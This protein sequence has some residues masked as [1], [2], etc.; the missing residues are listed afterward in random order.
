MLGNTYD[1]DHKRRRFLMLDMVHN[2]C[3]E[4]QQQ[5]LYASHI[6]DIF[7]LKPQ[8]LSLPDRIL[9][10][11]MGKQCAGEFLRDLEEVYDEYRF[12]QFSNANFD[13]DGINLLLA[14]ANLTQLTHEDAHLS[15]FK[16]RL[17]K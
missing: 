2:I 3:F 1:E 12:K 13:W 5:S 4:S 6:K 15:R 16:L 8:G 10:Q 7:V 9:V 11:I 17:D 14:R